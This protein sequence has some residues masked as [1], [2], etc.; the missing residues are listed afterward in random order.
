MRRNPDD[1]L[2]RPIV[3]IEGEI[4]ERVA[5]DVI[6]RILFLADESCR[7]LADHQLAR[8]LVRRQRLDFDTL[9]DIPLA[10]ATH[11]EI[12]AGTAAI[13]VTHGAN[14]HRS[15]SPAGSAGQRA[16]E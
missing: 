6:A 7:P 15:I 4:D 5:T 12:A 2:L 3:L 14:G 11:A 16:T 13:I 10:V 1:M 9:A 8:R